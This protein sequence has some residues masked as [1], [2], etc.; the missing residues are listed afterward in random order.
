MLTAPVYLHI[1]LAGTGL[2]LAIRRHRF[3]MLRVYFAAVVVIAAIGLAVLSFASPEAYRVYF[4]ISEIIHNL[5]LLTLALQMVADLLPHRPWVIGWCVFWVGLIF[6]GA[7]KQM[8]NT[9][10]ME[11][12]NISVAADFA[13]CGLLLAL[14]IPS[15]VPWTRAHALTAAGIVMV[16]LAAAVPEIRLLTQQEPWKLAMQFATLPGLLVLVAA[17]TRTG[18]Q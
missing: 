15:A 11:L 17:A 9:T 7:L 4:H 13:A 6:A 16:T 2:A 10:S 12:L 5:V 14:V 1:L 3:I 8:P 18:N